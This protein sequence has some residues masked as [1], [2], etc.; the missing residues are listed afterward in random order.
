MTDLL[1]PSTLEHWRRQ[2]IDFIKEI[3]RDSQT[4]RPFEIFPAQR[5]FFEHC[6]QRDDNERAL[7]PE[8][9]F[10]AIKKSAKTGTAALHVLTTTCL[11][12]GRFAEA[13]CCANDLEQAQSRVFQA[14]RRIVECSPHLRREADITASRI[15]FPQTGAVIQAISGDAPGAAGGHPV[16]SSFDELWG[17]T[18]ERARRLWDEMVPVPTRQFSVRLVTSYAGYSGDSQLLEELYKRGM[19]LPLVGDSLHAGDG[20]LMA[21]HTTPIC[22]WQDE[23]WLAEMRRSLRPNQFLRMICNQFVTT[24]SSFIDMV[25]WDKIVDP[26]ISPIASDKSLS[27]WVGVDASTKRDSTAIVAVTCAKNQV[28]LVCHKVFQPS[29]T[30]PLDF[31]E[32]VEATLINLSNNFRVRKVLYD[33]FQMAASA[34]RLANRGVVVEEFVPSSA[35]VTQASE[36]LHHLIQSNNFI[37]YPDAGLRTAVSQAVAVETARGTRIGKATPDHKIDAITALSLAC[38]AAVK[39]KATSVYN[40]QALAGTEPEPVDEAKLQREEYRRS[41]MERFGRPP[42]LVR[43]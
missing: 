23:R 20:L 3:L 38:L 6:W 12:G 32:T 34:K 14:I 39:G 27:I 22:K 17:V 40:F 5:E 19:A 8:Q 2:P 35:N 31:E 10:G 13:Y 25:L 30:Q 43:P 42:A 4:E 16:I 29:Q 1:Q 33:S 11:Y 28:R 7:Y 24:E 36:N 26:S 18:S 41:L 9:C 37:A 21:W 15:T